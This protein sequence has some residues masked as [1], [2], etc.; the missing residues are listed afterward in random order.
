MA[1]K[2]GRPSLEQLCALKER[3]RQEVVAELRCMLCKD[4]LSGKRALLFEHLWE[5]HHLFLGSAG[6]KT[7]KRCSSL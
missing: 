3:E 2:A 5:K 1:Q 7:R 6:E 4:V